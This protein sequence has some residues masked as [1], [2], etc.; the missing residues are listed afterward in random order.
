MSD[1]PQ[2]DHVWLY[3]R[4]CQVICPDYWK[5]IKRIGPNPWQGYVFG[6]CLIWGG[7]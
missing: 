6:R 7:L 1:W 5:V 4:I 3:F 2:K